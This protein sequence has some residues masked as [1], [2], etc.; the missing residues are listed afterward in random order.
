MDNLQ[1]YIMKELGTMFQRNCDNKVI[2]I[3]NDHLKAVLKG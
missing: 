1:S 2:L 3:D